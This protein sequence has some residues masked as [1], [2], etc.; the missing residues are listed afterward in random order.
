LQPE[1]LPGCSLLFQEIA[2]NMWLI[3]TTITLFTANVPAMADEYSGTIVQR[4][5]RYSRPVAQL[6]N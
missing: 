2:L 5:P 3:A 6:F 4:Q 1:V